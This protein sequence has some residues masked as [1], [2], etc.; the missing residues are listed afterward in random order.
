ME[1]GTISFLNDGPRSTHENDNEN[2]RPQAAKLHE[3]GRLTPT[4]DRPTLKSRHQISLLGF[5]LVVTVM[6]LAVSHWHTSRQLTTAQAE[7]RKL[8]DEL[9]RLS[10]DDRK[11]FHA[12]ALEGDL[13]SGPG[14]H[15]W[16]W[17][18][19]VPKGVRYWWNIACQDIPK[20]SP[21]PL[22]GVST[23]RSPHPFSQNADQTAVVTARLR[24][25]GD[26]DWMLSVSSKIG[27]SKE[28]L[29]GA[30]LKI[31]REQIKWL[32]GPTVFDGRVIGTNG[33]YVCDPD[34]P[35]IL[36]QQRPC[37]KLPN[38]RRGPSD[39][40][41]PGIMVWLSKTQT[42]IATDQTDASEP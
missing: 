36:L 14:P 6:C 31:P 18:I 26:G 38:G 32:Y 2:L 16:R 9:G 11:K 1:C 40:P 12:V 19:F 8:R 23:W 4:M 42:P 21:P 39:E 13:A 22:A 28:E 24:E 20:I 33:T 10:I 41:M 15:T 29:G 30:T 37:K 5:L 35:I 34:G 7:L 17:R 25:S 27:D 3:V